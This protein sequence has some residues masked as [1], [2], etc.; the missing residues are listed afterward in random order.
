MRGAVQ[1]AGPIGLGALRSKVPR[2]CSIG[3]GAATE[4]THS[5]W[6][7]EVPRRERQLSCRRLKRREGFSLSSARLPPQRPRLYRK[8]PGL[9]NRVL[10]LSIENA[11][12]HPGRPMSVFPANPT[13]GGN[14][15]A[16][17][18]DSATG[19]SAFTLM[20]RTPGMRAEAPGPG[21]PDSGC[22][23]PRIRPTPDASG[24]CPCREL[25]PPWR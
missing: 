2:L 9:G 6:M 19:G 15:F 7:D 8:L 14:D 4:S 3:H 21:I 22:P 13:R 11:I 1:S 20:N 10:A 24:Y 25:P 12:A 18:F 16:G 5:A 23:I 17:R